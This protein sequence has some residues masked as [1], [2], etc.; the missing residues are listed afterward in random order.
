M[1]DRQDHDG[2]VLFCCAMQGGAQSAHSPRCFQQQCDQGGAGVVEGVVDVVRGAGDQFL[3]RGDRQPEAEPP[4]RAKQGGERRSRVGDQTNPASREGIGFQVAQCPQSGHVVDEPH[5]PRAAERHPGT[6]RHRGDLLPQARGVGGAE[7]DRPA[8]AGGGRGFEFVAQRRVGYTQQ[9][10]INRFIEGG[11]RRR[12]GD[13]VDVFV[14]WIHQMHPRGTARALDDH[15]RTEAVGPGTGSDERHRPGAEHRVHR[16]AAQ[17]APWDHRCQER[18][19]SAARTLLL[20]R[21]LSASAARAACHP[22]MPHTPPPAWVAEL[23]LYSP[24][25][26]VR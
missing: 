23:P 3:A 25:I 19:P 4:V 10:Q 18:P 11:Q 2:H 17:S 13:P 7:H 24:A 14:A 21:F 15:S 12:A 5:A 26:G 6:R 8:C 1:A 20:P 22:G 16:G 9:H